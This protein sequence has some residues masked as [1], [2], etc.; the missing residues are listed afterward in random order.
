MKFDK[1]FYENVILKMCQDWLP[2]KEF[3][4]NEDYSY[5]QDVVEVNVFRRSR[6]GWFVV[7]GLKDGSY[8]EEIEIPLELV[9]TYLLELSTRVV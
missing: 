1:M 8:G 7:F 3:I 9:L 4:A 5:F 6:D 2:A